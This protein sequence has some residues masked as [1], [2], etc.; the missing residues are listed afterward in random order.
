MLKTAWS[1]GL[2]KH[3]LLFTLFN[4]SLYLFIVFF[5]P[6]I[7]FN[8][9]NYEFNSHHY[10]TDPRSVGKPFSLFSALAQFDAQWYLKIAGDGYRFIPGS[11]ADIGNKSTLDNLTYAYFPLFPVLIRAA[12]FIFSDL[13]ISA[14]I[15]SN[16][17]LLLNFVSVYLIFSR[18]FTPSVAAK[19][20]WLL[21][22]FPFSVFYRSYF[23]E[24]LQL[25]LS[26]W[27]FYFLLNR[28]F[29]LSAVFLALLSTVKG[30]AL[31]SLLIFA[32]V[33]CRHLFLKHI[34]WS[35]FLLSGFISLAGLGVWLAIN[36]FTT[37]NLF[38]FQQALSSW[39]LASTPLAF[40]RNFFI[41]SHL[42][43]FPL[44]YFHYSV[45]DVIVCYFSLFL[46][47]LSRRR[48]PRPLWWYAFSLWAVP[49]FTRDLMSFS[50][51]QSA[52][53]PLFLY[54]AVRSN[55]WIFR[56]I[57][58]LWIPLLFLVSLYFSDWYWIG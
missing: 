51:Y 7:P 35:K 32:V 43:G 45:I 24:N 36:Y 44:H 54:L 11:P 38:F 15:V 9:T 52:S 12:S 14:F 41:I 56:L 1:R 50:R 6:V 5:H 17:L 21:F 55:S 29:L 42:S 22:T 49:F 13:E 46:L 27:F 47:F 25:L 20:A 10:L 2:L 57:L 23:A 37:G 34:S 19:T 58:L 28:N 4:L 40:F 30:L 8:L 3:T 33:L 53:F 18:K 39:Y 48:L 16:L 31:P 26:L